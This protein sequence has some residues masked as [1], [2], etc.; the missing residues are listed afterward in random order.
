MFERIID[1]FE[2]YDK[3]NIPDEIT[4]TPIVDLVTEDAVSVACYFSSSDGTF[5]GEEADLFN[6]LFGTDKTAAEL[7]ALSSDRIPILDHIGKT[8][9]V[10]A[11][12][13]KELGIYKLRKTMIVPLIK[14]YEAVATDIIKSNDCEV[15]NYKEYNDFFHDIE[16]VITAIPDPDN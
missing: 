16:S 6:G 5:S 11:F 1:V 2:K 4:D 14:F 8:F 13:E 12:T 9:N 10:I 3:S 15:Q 7:S